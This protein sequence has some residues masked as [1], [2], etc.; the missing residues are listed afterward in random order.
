M[1]QKQANHVLV[2][3]AKSKGFTNGGPDFEF[4]GERFAIMT[5]SGT[6]EEIV[7]KLIDRGDGSYEL[8][9]V[10]PVVLLS[11][12]GADPELKKLD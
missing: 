1:N 4:R 8:F 12:W 7:D 11:Q 10:D 5:D 9:G 6:G 2:Q 3:I